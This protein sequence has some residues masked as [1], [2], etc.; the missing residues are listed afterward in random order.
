MAT[1]A[2]RMELGIDSPTLDTWGLLDT[3]ILEHKI[4]LGDAIALWADEP[5]TRDEGLW[6]RPHRGESSGPQLLVLAQNA[7]AF[8][9]VYE[10]VVVCGFEEMPPRLQWMMH[11]YSQVAAHSQTFALAAP[12]SAAAPDEDA[13]GGSEWRGTPRERDRPTGPQPL[14]RVLERAA[15]H[16]ADF[17]CLWPSR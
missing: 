4:K 16:V 6:G 12:S 14:P 11:R 17:H 9:H 8:K 13:L 3:L 1:H 10:N 2:V 15:L 5:L 7:T